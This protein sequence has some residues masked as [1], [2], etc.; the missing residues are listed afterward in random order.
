MINLLA[1]IQIVSID[2]SLTAWLTTTG[3]YLVGLF[4]WMIWYVL[5]D[6]RDELRKR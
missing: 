2:G 6:I 3:V 5:Y 4:S 1:E